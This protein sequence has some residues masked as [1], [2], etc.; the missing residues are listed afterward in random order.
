MPVPGDFDGDALTDLRCSGHRGC[1]VRR[2]PATGT[3]AI[4]RISSTR[5]PRRRTPILPSTSIRRPCRCSADFSGDGKQDFVVY[6]PPAA[7][8]TSLH[9]REHAR[10]RGSSSMQWGLPGDLPVP[11]DFEGDGKAD[12][13]VWRPSKAVVHPLLVERL[14]RGR[15]P[16]RINGASLA[17]CPRP[18]TSTVTRRPTSPSGVH[19]KAGGTS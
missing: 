7:N 12:L 11:A 2:P 14:Q 15:A 4:R 9:E 5:R 8:G 19:R 18:S 6:S 13:A 1:S 16:R 17:T 10:Q 3:F